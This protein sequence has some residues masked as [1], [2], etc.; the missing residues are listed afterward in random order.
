[1]A[2][3]VAPAE[4]SRKAS[5]GAGTV[6]MVSTRPSSHDTASHNTASH[7]TAIDHT[8]SQGTAT[9]EP[10]SGDTAIDGRTRHYGTFY[11]LDP[12]DRADGGDPADDRPLLVVWGN[13]QAEA[14]RQLLAASPTLELRTV[15]I[16]PVFE[17][18]PADLGPLHRLVERASV[19]ISQPVKDNYRDLPLGTNQLA[20][21]LRQGGAIIR[22]PVVRCAAYHPFQAIVR[23]P[24]DPSRDPPVVPY[25]DLRTLASARR[26]DDLLTADV[27]VQA[28][29]AVGQASKAELRR[30]EQS[31]CDVGISDLFDQ[32]EAGDMFTINHPGNRVLVELA[33]RIQLAVGR[34][35]DAVD[36]GRNLLGELTAPVPA[37]ALAALGLP[38]IAAPSWRVRGREI[39][40]AEVHR[41]QL[42]WYRDNPWVVDAGYARHRET[43]ETLGFA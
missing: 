38:G 4:P 6:R 28:C 25:H 11:G 18:T 9:D 41:L 43:L 1:M 42:Q 21:Q 26:G 36:P 32:P 16:P 31:Q 3:P 35:A 10:A 23:D 22:W 2:A 30:R 15:R 34:P 39:P 40:G 19:L 37:P 5:T 24:R 33:Q 12:A 17:L 27:S 20:S 13:C 8:A 14:V 29:R 7:D